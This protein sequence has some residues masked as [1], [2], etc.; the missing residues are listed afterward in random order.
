MV[1]L[2][3]STCRTLRMSS[4]DVRHPLVNP[5]SKIAR[6]HRPRVAVATASLPYRAGST[7]PD[8]AHF[9]LGAALLVTIGEAWLVRSQ[10]EFLRTY[11][12][13]SHWEGHSASTSGPFARLEPRGE[14][15][16]SGDIKHRIRET[17]TKRL[18][19]CYRGATSD[20]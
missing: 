10:S 16:R 5:R 1:R 14:V 19:L 9:V 3:R 2:S 4:S 7:Q 13:N 20:A 11:A 12:T 18:C 17:L 15:L 8:E 6:S